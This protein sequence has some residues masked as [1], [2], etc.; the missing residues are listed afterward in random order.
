MPHDQLSGI[1]RR[2]QVIFLVL[3]QHT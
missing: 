1:S 2:E 3:D